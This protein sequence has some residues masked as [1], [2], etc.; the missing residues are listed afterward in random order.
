MSARA[1][2]E[3]IAVPGAAPDAVL[4]PYASEARYARVLVDVPAQ[5]ALF[6]AELSWRWGVLVACTP[7]FSRWWRARPAAERPR[8][9]F[10]EVLS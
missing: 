4:C 3:V 7:E 5:P 10:L 1:R 9:F 2:I 8:G 6:D